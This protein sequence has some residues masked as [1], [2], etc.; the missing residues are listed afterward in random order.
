M[1]ITIQSEEVTE[2]RRRRK[3]SSYVP[4][5]LSYPVHVDDNMLTTHTLPF[6]QH[7]QVVGVVSSEHGNNQYSETGK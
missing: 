3:R 7:Y 6:G 1:T 4:V 5:S 2:K